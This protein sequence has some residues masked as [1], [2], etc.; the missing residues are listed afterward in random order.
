MIDNSLQ[1]V[2]GVDIWRGVVCHD[3]AYVKNIL[4][5]YHLIRTFNNKYKYVFTMDSQWNQEL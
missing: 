2:R 3:I 1:I 4:I 5:V